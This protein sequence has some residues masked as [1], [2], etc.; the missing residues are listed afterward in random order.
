MRQHPC[1][2]EFLGFNTREYFPGRDDEDEKEE[3]KEK[4]VKTTVAL[5]FEFLPFSVNKVSEKRLMSSTLK[6]RIAVEVV[7]FKMLLIFY[8]KQNL[9]ILYILIK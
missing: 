3:D 6:A 8:G 5:F 9:C 2:C 4:V 7:F 1:I